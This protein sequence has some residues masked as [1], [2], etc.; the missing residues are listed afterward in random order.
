ME[1]DLKRMVRPRRTLWIALALAGWLMP[2]WPQNSPSPTTSRQTA[3]S[4]EREGKIAEAEAAWLALSE[5]HP[6]DPEAFA[7]LGLLEARQ[8]RYTDALVHYRKAMALN[9]SMPGLRLNMGLTLFK[10][11]EYKD[12]LEAFQPLLKTQTPASEEAERLNVLIGMS[13][14]GLGEYAAAIPYLQQASGRDAQN[15]PL[16]L[17]LAHSCLLSRQYQCVLDSYHQ[18]VTL[19]AESAEADM[20]VGEALDEMKDASG[21]IREFRAAIQA[22][23]REPNAHFGLGYLLWTQ[24]QYGEA[25]QEFQAELDNTPDY[26]QAILYLADSDIQLNRM[27]E[28]QVLLEKLVKSNP[29]AEMGRRDLGIIYAEADRDEDALRELKAAEALKPDDVSVH[30]RLG[31]L[32]RSMGKTAEAKSELKQASSLNKAVA[33]AVL[34]VMSDPAAKEKKSAAAPAAK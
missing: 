30:W 34:D 9:P 33:D 17:T 12:A 32:Y 31:R 7:H 29:S 11:G 20:L 2:A 13:H 24:M 25:A 3:F 18:M 21:A 26:T 28:A 10:T 1:R 8:E 15:L 5:A 22:N 6:S 16:L 19:N 4:L 23:P 27:A 14:Y